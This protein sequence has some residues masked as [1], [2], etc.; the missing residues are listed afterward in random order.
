MRLRAPEKSAPNSK[1]K[2]GKGAAKK[3][4]METSPLRMN[5]D[6]LCMQIPLVGVLDME[7]QHGNLSAIF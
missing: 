7:S 3:Q 1:V 5:L 4:K 2:K 6:F